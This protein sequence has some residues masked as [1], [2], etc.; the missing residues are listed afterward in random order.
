MK[1]AETGIGRIVSTRTTI[2]LSI[3]F[4]LFETSEMKRNAMLTTFY[5]I[6]LSIVLVDDFA[7]VGQ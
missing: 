5:P 3:Q 1:S 4:C 6:F 2:W 7:S